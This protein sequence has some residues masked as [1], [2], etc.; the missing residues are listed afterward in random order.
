MTQRR[1]FPRISFQLGSL[2]RCLRRCVLRLASLRPCAV[3]SLHLPRLLPLPDQPFDF[4]F[5]FLQL[6]FQLN[7]FGLRDPRHIV[8]LL[9]QTRIVFL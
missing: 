7:K 2:R 8:L 3:A 5:F 6:L 1:K 4:L 9:F